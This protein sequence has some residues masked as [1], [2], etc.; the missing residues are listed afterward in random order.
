MNAWI[1]NAT[2]NQLTTVSMPIDPATQLAVTSA[3][4]MKAPWSTPFD[5]K[6]TKNAPFHVEPK[7]DVTVRMMKRERAYVPYARRD[8]VQ[9]LELPYIDPDLSMIVILPDA[10]HGLAA[11]EA[12]LTPQ[13]LGKWIARVSEQAVDVFLPRFRSQTSMDATADIRALANEPQLGG[14]F[15]GAR[16]EV[17][18]RGTTAAADFDITLV[19]STSIPPPPPV[20][21]ADHPFLYLVRSKATGNLYFLGRVVQP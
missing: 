18:E 11:I 4:A 12:K 5:V 19:T 7:R 16:I 8:G 14:A 6:E 20:F 2:R 13:L 10:V 17:D 21:R 1:A 3:I 15:T 9:L